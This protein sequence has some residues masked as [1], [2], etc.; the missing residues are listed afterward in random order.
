MKFLPPEP[1]IPADA[2]FSKDVFDREDF[3]KSLS[4]VV[5]KSE[6]NLVIFVNA[7]WGEGKTTFCKMWLA[8]LKLSQRSAIYFDAFAA[9]YFDD[10]FVSFSGE[11]VDFLKKTYP[12]DNEMQ[13]SRRGFAATALTVCKKMAGTLLKVGIGAATAGVLNAAR[14]EEFQEAGK[15]L[16]AGVAD[17]GQEILKDKIENYEKE[18]DSFSHFKTR[19]SE[20]AQKVKERQGFPLTI[21]VDELDRCRPDYALTVLERIKHLFEVPNVVFVLFINREQIENYTSRMLGDGVNATEYL[22]KFGHLHTNLPK[23]ERSAQRQQMLKFC[24]I[25]SAHYRIT[26]GQGAATFADCVTRVA[27][28]FSLSLR[29][30]QRVFAI[31]SIYYAQVAPGTARD[32]PLISI[33]T[34]LKVKRPPIYKQLSEGSLSWAD[35]ISETGLVD[36]LS[37]DGRH[38]KPD[39]LRRLFQYPLQ[40][41]ASFIKLSPEA[42]MSIK[43]PSELTLDFNGKREELIPYFCRILDRF[44]L[45]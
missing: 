22:Q 15:E 19:L 5:A 40:D 33:L 1:E 24:E 31:A 17:A 14:L 35:F 34:I 3:A 29:D 16:A 13:V 25:L 39:W 8:S 27:A 36:K 23:N 43:E 37:D 32:A 21:I 20:V 4:M 28:H 2:P 41:E 7:P 42:H 6:D 30:I 45:G 38:P 9:D 26:S 12:E 18:R 10:P 11:I 44:R